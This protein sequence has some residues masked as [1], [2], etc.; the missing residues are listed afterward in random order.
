MQLVDWDALT[1]DESLWARLVVCPEKDVD[2]LVTKVNATNHRTVVRIIR[3]SRCSTRD[4]LLQEWAAALQFPY[5]FGHNWEALDECLSDLEW[6]PGD[7]YI[8]FVTHVDALLPGDDQGFK[9]LME[10]LSGIVIE[11]AADDA[12]RPSKLFRVVFHCEPEKAMDTL[13]RMKQAG[14]PIEST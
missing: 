6:L 7:K 9:T 13:K 5:Y 4:R 1:S 10:I 12:F 11:W 3:G 8:L 2:N 14:V